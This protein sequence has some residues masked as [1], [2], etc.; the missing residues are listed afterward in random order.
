MKAYLANGLFSE[1]DIMYNKLIADTM[2]SFIPGVELYVPQENEEINDKESYADSMQI[3]EADKEKLMESDFLIAVI[4]G[5]EIDSGVAAEI[6]LFSSLG[7][8]I[9]ALYTDVRLKGTK[10]HKKIHALKEDPFENQF[11]YKNLFVIGMI[12]ASGG[13]IYSRLSQMVAHLSV[14]YNHTEEN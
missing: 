14:K 1:S 3:F 11:A 13:E 7:K 8:P 5:P 6:G 10:N 9:Y 4:D 2:R 12:K